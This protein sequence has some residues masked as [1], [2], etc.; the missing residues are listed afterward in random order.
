VTSA[1]NGTSILG[2]YA[3]IIYD[4]GGLLDMNVAGYPTVSTPAQFGRKGAVAYADLKVIPGISPTPAP[5]VTGLS[6]LSQTKFV[7]N[8]VGWRNF[9][10]GA[11]TGSLGT[12]ASGATYSF[13]SGT[14]YWSSLQSNTNGFL[15]TSNT[16]LNGNQSDRILGGRQ[17]LIALLLRGMASTAADRANLQV[18]LQYLGTFS[19]EFNRPTWKPS[20]PAGATLPAYD[21]A[22]LAKTPTP[23]TSVA[24]NRDLTA[25]RVSAGFTRSDGTPVNAGDPLLKNRFSLARL[26]GIGPAG[27]NATQNTTLVNAVLVPAT[28]ATIQRDFGL[29]WN[30]GLN[31]WDYVG[32]S[33][34]T[35]Q[36]TIKRLDQVAGENPPREPNFFELLKAVILSGSVGL[37]SGSGSTFVAA[38]LKYYDTATSLSADYHIMQIG[39]NIIDAWDSDNIPTFIGFKDPS[40]ATVYEAAGIENVPYLNKIVFCPQIP[41]STSLNQTADAWLVPSLWNP[42]Q[43][44][45]ASTITGNRVRIALTGSPTYTA[46]F[47]VGST[48]YTSNAIVTFPTPTID[49][50]AN[51]FMAPAP[52]Q[53][54]GLTAPLTPP[55]GSVSSVGSPE[56]FYGFHF[57]FT[58]PPNGSQ[59]NKDNTDAAYPHFGTTSGN[60]NIE[61][62]VQ[63]PD[64]SYKTY[65]KWN[66]AATLN[67]LSAKGVKNNGDWSNTNKLS[68]PE[69]VALDPRTL[70]FGVWGSDANGQGSTGNAKKNASYGAEDSVDQDKG[71]LEF[72][73][74]SRPQ[75]SSFT[76]TPSA[77]SDVSSADLSLYATNGTASNHYI[78]LDGVQRRG[79]WT[80]DVN[81]TG[82]KA[83]IMYASAKTPPAGK[84]LDRPQILSGPFQSVA[85]LGQVFRDQPWK[86]LSFTSATTG[87]T[88]V[89]ADAGLLDVFTLPGQPGQKRKLGSVLFSCISVFGASTKTPMAGPCRPPWAMIF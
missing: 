72:I 81:G 44:G 18:A 47:T 45:S 23:E 1:S 89:S 49:V 79:D 43:N 76:V 31:H 28:A 21:Y 61:L 22:T 2:R 55:T 66:I 30:S 19:R 42:H 41:T 77:P 3:Y 57:V 25:V 9:S 56:R 75:G 40:S 16:S 24:I 20:T 88:G 51:G 37:G 13:A 60:G 33:G 5:V 84:Y 32:G 10:S 87:A 36:T 53:E 35:V 12:F 73:N 70:R 14:N 48:T 64:T 80:T 65:Q 74:W 15:L 78:D 17:Q 63:L 26:G 52:P 62:Q 4:E 34:S 82:S 39:A 7:N 71:K 50:S 11:A 68:D 85:E 29:L 54:T 38:E 59:V 27:P 46:G 69:Y 58:P 83:T 8:I 86:T 67:P 6:L